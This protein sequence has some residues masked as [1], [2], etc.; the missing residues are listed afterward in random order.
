M[1]RKIY[2]MPGE[3]SKAFENIAENLEN[4]EKMKSKS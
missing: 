2:I 4:F 1:I 3:I